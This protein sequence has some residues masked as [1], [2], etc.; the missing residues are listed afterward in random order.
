MP[1]KEA[2][3]KWLKYSDKHRR[4]L[5]KITIKKLWAEK[6]GATINDYTREIKIYGK[7]LYITIESAPLRNELQ[8]QREDI[9]VWVNGHLS[10]EEA[11][12]EVVIR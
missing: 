3:Q 10:G 8:Y 7:R 12:E 2:M 6:M 4:K 11:I 1:I 5:D 9:K